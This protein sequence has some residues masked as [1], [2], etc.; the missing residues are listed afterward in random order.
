MWIVTAQQSISPQ[1]NVTGFTKCCMSSAMDVTDGMWNGV[2]TVG[3]LGVGVGEMKTLTVQ[4]ERVTL[5][6]TGR[7]NVTC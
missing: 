7:Q 3:M 5:S 4:M 6:G 2:R 1:E